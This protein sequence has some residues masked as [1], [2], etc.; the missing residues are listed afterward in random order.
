MKSNEIIYRIKLPIDEYYTLIF[1]ARW[2]WKEF[3]KTYQL[4]LE[5]RY[6]EYTICVQ[7]RT[8]QGTHLAF[9][10]KVDLI[11]AEPEPIKQY[12]VDTLELIERRYDAIDENIYIV[13]RYGV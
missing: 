5:D 1:N 10:N 6:G 7:D 8:R 13:Y 3:I 4:I 11:I 2:Y 9:L 12:I